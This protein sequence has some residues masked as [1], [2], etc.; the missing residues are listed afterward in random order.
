MELKSHN[1]LSEI[2]EIYAFLLNN[3]PN[4]AQSLDKN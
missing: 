2:I 4:Q 3:G 1:V